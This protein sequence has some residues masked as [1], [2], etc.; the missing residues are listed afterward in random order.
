MD[1]SVLPA[2]TGKSQ[3]FSRP[4]STLVG[5]DLDQAIAFG[6]LGYVCGLLFNW[7]VLFRVCIKTSECH[8]PRCNGLSLMVCRRMLLRL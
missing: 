8:P 2:D 7:V 5:A 4:P 1:A 6:I 3:S